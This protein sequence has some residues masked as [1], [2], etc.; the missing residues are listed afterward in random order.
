VYNGWTMSL[1]FILETDEFQELLQRINRNEAGLQVNGVIAAARPY[2]LAALHQATGKKIVFIRPRSFSL[3]SFKNRSRYFWDSLPS[4]L[5]PMHLPPLS[6]SPYLAIAPSLDAISSRMDFFYKLLYS[7]PPLVIS[8]IPGLF[9]PMPH[10]DK[11]QDF[12]IELE[13][14]SSIS[15]ELLLQ[16]IADSGY[17]QEDLISSHGE[18]AWRGGIVDIFSP[19]EAHPFR[20]EFSG[21]KIASLR[22]FDPASQRS[23]RQLTSIIIP[24]LREFPNEKTLLSGWAQAA[25]S[26]SSKDMKRNIDKISEEIQA[27]NFPAH[28]AYFALLQKESFVP[29]TEYLGEYVFIIEDFS[30]VEKEWAEARSIFQEQYEE[31]RKKLEFNLSPEEIFPSDL[32]EQLKKKAV[33]LNEL[34]VVSASNPIDFRFQSVPRFENH[35]SREKYRCCWGTCQEVLPILP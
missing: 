9:K 6:E 25:R 3:E 16:K 8:N 28:F 34:P 17:S 7:W 23:V 15:R 22:E 24:S 13:L 32:W 4:D 14:G 5:F 19:W 26:Q 18:Y 2:F 10:P 1:D 35:F 31:A 11:L 27:G 21:E 12:F 29:Y 30:R 20:I 33:H